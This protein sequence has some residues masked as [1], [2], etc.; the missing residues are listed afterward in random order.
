MRSFLND[1][2]IDYWHD[3]EV[4][5]RPLSAF[6]VILSRPEPPCFFLLGLF[7]LFLQHFELGSFRALSLLTA[8]LGDL[9]LLLAFL[10]FDLGLYLIRQD[11]PGK[12][13][14]QGLIPLSL[15]FD[16]DSRRNVFQVDAGG[17]LIDLLASS[18]AR[19]DKFLDDILLGYSQCLHA[20]EEG[21]LFFFAD[22]RRAHRYD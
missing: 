1:Q 19:P 12:K 6:Q 10:S 21:F 18:A 16:F 7:F 20:L 13:A 22:A 14:V 17:G 4:K 9:L 11:A 3:K 8:D 2:G 15:A 5:P